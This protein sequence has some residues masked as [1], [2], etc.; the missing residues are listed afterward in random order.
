MIDENSSS[1]LFFRRGVVRV[2]V[3]AALILAGCG[4]G[5]AS[6]NGGP[7]PKGAQEVAEAMLED[8]R[9]GNF[10]KACGHLSAEGLVRYEESEDSLAELLGEPG[11]EGDCESTL[12]ESILSRFP[13]VV[14]N[15]TIS[16]DERQVGL[17]VHNDAEESNMPFLLEPEQG[18][19]KISMMGVQDDRATDETLELVEEGH[20]DP[21]AHPELY[22]P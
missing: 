17:R 7:D 3:V 20:F 11:G 16:P 5:G 6:E 4:G 9:A 10:E 22:L 12:E 8:A 21:G 2:S 14:S 1:R 13:Y 18:E 15:L 19:W